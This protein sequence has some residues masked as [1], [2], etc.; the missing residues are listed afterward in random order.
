V[1]VASAFNNF[2]KACDSV[3]REALDNILIEPG[4]PRKLVGLIKMCLNEAYSTVRTGKD[5][6]DK[7]LNQNGL[8]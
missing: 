4:I 2:E 3:M 1:Y 5:T 8:K 6:S 7:F